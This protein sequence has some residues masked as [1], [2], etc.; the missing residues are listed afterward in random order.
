M[1]ELLIAD[2]SM[3][4]RFSI[5][6]IAKQEGFETV[7]A[8]DGDECLAIIKRN[9]PDALC[10][11]LNMPGTDGLGV[12]T[13]LRALAPD[14]PVAVITADI[15]ETTRRRVLDNGVRTIF[16]KPFPME[17][18]KEFLRGVRS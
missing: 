5:A 2:D 4:Q 10:L 18:L 11:D 16:N 15:Q 7:E 13:E 12:L 3:F 14:L 6:K 9:L 8:A 17:D 1:P